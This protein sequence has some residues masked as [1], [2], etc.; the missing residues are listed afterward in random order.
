MN[1]KIIS[2]LLGDKHTWNSTTFT[3]LKLL[4]LCLRTSSELRS[5]KGR[6]RGVVYVKNDKCLVGLVEFS[7]LFDLAPGI[8]REGTWRGN[9][10]VWL[11]WTSR[12]SAWVQNWDQSRWYRMFLSEDCRRRENPHILWGKLFHTMLANKETI[13][14]F[15]V[16]MT[17]RQNVYSLVINYNLKRN[18]LETPLFMNAFDYQILDFIS[19]DCLT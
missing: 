15:T 13:F 7:L 6:C 17:V 12:R 18:E 4:S 19:L 11:W 16:W 8:G 5:F 2:E 1:R 14:L 10:R 3:S 9:R